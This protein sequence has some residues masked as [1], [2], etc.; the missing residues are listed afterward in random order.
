M[1]KLVTVTILFFVAALLSSCAAGMRGGTSTT[2]ETSSVEASSGGWTSKDVGWLQKGMSLQQVTQKFGPADRTFVD[3][4]GNKILEY[5]KETERGG[6]MTG[7]I[8]FGTL[9]I[10]SGKDSA[11]V[12][13]LRV[14]VSKEGTVV[15][16]SYEENVVSA[17]IPGMINTN[18]SALSAAPIV[19]ETPAVVGGKP[20]AQVHPVPENNRKSI[21]PA[22]K[23]T[24][25]S[26]SMTTTQIQQRLS[27]LG[28]QPGPADGKIGK[29]TIKALKNF[30]K[31]NNLPITGK[32]DNETVNKL[33]QKT[34]KDNS[35]QYVSPSMPKT[36]T[37]RKSETVKAR[38]PLDL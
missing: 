34:A 28:Y 30:Q 15:N 16:F 13:I 14:V 33:R 19:N 11:F 18:M 32:A 7:L 35:E 22:Q 29:S 8:K 6:R 27:Q 9:G 26:P 10:L 36:E 2:G 20:K 21:T 12:D 17:P 31:D 4:N 1:K 25:S 3:A 38:S 5:K 24:V 37:P 23:I